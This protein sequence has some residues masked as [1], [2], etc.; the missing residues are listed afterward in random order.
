MSVAREDVRGAAPRTAQPGREPG[1]VLGAGRLR[2]VEPGNRR[3]DAAGESGHRRVV[4]HASLPHGVQGGGAASRVHDHRAHPLHGGHG[5]GDRGGRLLARRGTSEPRGGPGRDRAVGW[6]AQAG[7]AGRG[8]RAHLGVEAARAQGQRGV[9]LE[10]VVAGAEGEEAVERGPGL[11]GR[12]SVS[13]RAEEKGPR[14]AGAAHRDARETLGGVEVE[15]GRGPEVAARR[16]RDER[17]HEAL[18]DQ[19]LPERGVR[20]HPADRGREAGEIRLRPPPRDGGLTEAE[21]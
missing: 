18:V 15:K 4:E 13:E 2:P 7:E 1:P 21:V 17:R 11:L 8:A 12:A 9:R 5:R 3:L 10:R 20:L 19:P 16:E 6:L 14:L